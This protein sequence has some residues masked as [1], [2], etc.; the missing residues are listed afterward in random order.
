MGTFLY[1]DVRRFPV[2]VQTGVKSTQQV[3]HCGFGSS[4][5]RKLAQSPHLRSQGLS[6][7]M[8]GFAHVSMHPDQVGT[9]SN[10]GDWAHPAGSDSVILQWDWGSAPVTRFPAMLR[11]LVQGPCLENHRPGRCLRSC[12]L[13]FLLP[14]QSW[15][16]RSQSLTAHGPS[17]SS[18][19]SRQC[20][21]GQSFSALSS[22][23][24]NVGWEDI[25]MAFGED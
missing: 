23:S 19:N 25:S 14:G 1:A 16:T 12:L 2:R 7:K 3:P 24:E 10:A 21:L 22:T 13:E 18:D 17:P 20:D 8:R 5:D 15:R 4:P 11:R 6:S 9:C